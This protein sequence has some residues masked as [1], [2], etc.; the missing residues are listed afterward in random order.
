[1]APYIFVSGW[2]H[3]VGTYCLH[4]QDIFSTMHCH[5]TEDYDLSSQHNENLKFRT[6]ETNSLETYVT[7][8]DILKAR[9]WS[10]TI[11]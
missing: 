1:M 3:F 9:M 5:N 7:M 6:E 10:V 11:A 2:Q 8:F 4:L